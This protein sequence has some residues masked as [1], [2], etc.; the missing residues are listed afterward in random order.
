MAKQN[1]TAIVW[2]SHSYGLTLIFSQL[3]SQNLSFKKWGAAA[4]LSVSAAYTPLFLVMV[5][6]S[7]LFIIF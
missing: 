4:G 2:T 5:I 1:V 6:E 3:F 7:Q